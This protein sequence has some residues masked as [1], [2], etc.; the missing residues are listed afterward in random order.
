MIMVKMTYEIYWTH[1]G[2]NSQYFL[3]AW[4]PTTRPLTTY[5]KYTSHGVPFQVLGTSCVQTSV[6]LCDHM[7]SMCDFPNRVPPTTFT[8]VMFQQ[9]L[10][11]TVHAQHDR[12]YNHLIN[13][14]RY[15]NPIFNQPSEGIPSSKN[16]SLLDLKVLDK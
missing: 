5:D 8:H 10:Y 9:L 7:L 14:E 2:K 3:T 1:E 12:L 4:F 11:V 13:L 6:S 15:G 16:P